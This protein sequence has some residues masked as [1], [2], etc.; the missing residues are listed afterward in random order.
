VEHFLL[1]LSS[2]Y[3]LERTLL[4]SFMGMMMIRVGLVGFFLFVFGGDFWSF[5]VGA[6]GFLCGAGLGLVGA[7]LSS[8]YRILFFLLWTPS[9]WFKLRPFSVGFGSFVG[10][11]WPLGSLFFWGGLLFNPGRPSSSFYRNLNLPITNQTLKQGQDAR[12]GSFCCS[13]AEILVFADLIVE[14]NLLYSSEPL[15][16][17]PF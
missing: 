13:A 15:S 12:V 10:L 11:C 2:N 1:F 6:L 8:S 9:L 3:Q 4:K 14:I 5:W 7:V 17:I 16:S